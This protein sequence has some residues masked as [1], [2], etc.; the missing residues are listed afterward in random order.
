MG[1]RD[2]EWLR[3]N[4]ADLQR[5]GL[6][7]ESFGPGTF[8]LESLPPFLPADRPQQLM[9]EVIE[10]LQAAGSAAPRMRLGE[11]MIAKTVCRHAVKANDRLREPEIEKLITDLLACELPVLLPT[12]PA[13]H[14]SDEPWRAGEKVW[15]AKLMDESTVDSSNAEA[16]YGRRHA[17]A[18]EALRALADCGALSRI[19]EM[20]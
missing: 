10:E 16:G 3:R 15:A 7:L 4:L 19:G 8:K 17:H 1:P 5:M 6:G 18:D 2:A 20:V 13:H 9:R 12:W 14:D 11:E